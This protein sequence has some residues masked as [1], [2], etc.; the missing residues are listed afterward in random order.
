MQ[1]NPRRWRY[2]CDTPMTVYIPRG[3]DYKPVEVRCG[4]TA[5]D[6]GVNQC[7]KCSAAP[8]LRPPRTPDEGDD[9]A[10]ERD[11]IEGEREAGNVP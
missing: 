1:I 6:G 5:Y 9:I 10:D 4:S 8:G 7:D 2:G 11:Y 3:F